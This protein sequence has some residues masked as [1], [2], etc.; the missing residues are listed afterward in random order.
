M[1][2]AAVIAIVPALILGEV[3][4]K[5]A[6]TF[7]D[8]HFV[9]SYDKGGDVAQ[10]AYHFSLIEKSKLPVYVEGTCLSACTMILRNPLACARPGAFF[11]FHAARAYNP[12]T[13]ETAGVS[14][15]GNKLLWYHYPE[16][17]RARLNNQ[18]TLETDYV[19]GTEWLQLYK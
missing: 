10:Y 11:G 2:A 18:H 1:G 16:K 4:K 12:N 15:S 6:Y 5:P 13:L 19:K 3:S 9:L 17:V 14:E 8:D 7:V